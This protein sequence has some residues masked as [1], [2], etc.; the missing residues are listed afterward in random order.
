M[1]VVGVGKICGT[2]KALQ[3]RAIH[4]LPLRGP[5][6]LIYFLQN[7]PVVMETYVT[8]TSLFLGGGEGECW[9]WA[10][11]SQSLSEFNITNV[12]KTIQ[13]TRI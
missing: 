11:N 13:R 12:W 9:S 4:L 6:R 5:F 2:Y 7:P 10:F 3:Y 8:V 1:S